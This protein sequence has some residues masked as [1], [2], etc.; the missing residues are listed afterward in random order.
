M[1]DTLPPE[2]FWFRVARE[3]GTVQVTALEPTLETR[4]LFCSRSAK[5]AH[6]GARRNCNRIPR[7]PTNAAKIPRESSRIPESEFGR[8]SCR[9]IG[10]GNGRRDD[11]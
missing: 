3:G 11:D 4:R 9:R 5:H 6:S 8:A 7:L 2:A 1:D 10:A